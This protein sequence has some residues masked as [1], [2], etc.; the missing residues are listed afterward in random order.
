MSL[1][2][3]ALVTSFSIYLP[4]SL[5]LSLSDTCEILPILS[6]FFPTIFFYSFLYLTVPLLNY[7]QSLCLVWSASCCAF[8]ISL[9]LSLETLQG[10]SLPKKFIA[11]PYYFINSPILHSVPT[12]WSPTLVLAPT[13]CPLLPPLSRLIKSCKKYFANDD[14]GFCGRPT[15]NR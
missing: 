10:T 9:S 13:P 15:V 1:F 4:L 3:G 7:S 8:T 2:L 11:L 6:F 12:S 5:S 14:D